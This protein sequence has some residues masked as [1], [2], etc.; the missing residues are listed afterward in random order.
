VPTSDPLE[1]VRQVIGMA[2]VLTQKDGNTDIKP[3]MEEISKLRQESRETEREMWKTQLADIKA[4]LEAKENAPT[5][6][7]LLPDGSNL[8]VIVEK[9]VA[10]AVENGLGESDNSWW[11]DPLKQLLPA[12][13]PVLG[14][15]LQ[16]FMQPAPAPPAFPMPPAHFQA[17]APM[18][19]Q[20]AQLPAPQQQPPPAVQ[21]QPGVFT[22]G[23]P[24]LDSLLMQI[25]VPLA[26]AL[27]GDGAPDS[28]AE[29]AEYFITEFGYD[30]F[31]QLAASGVEPIVQMLYAYPPL[32]STLKPLPRE[33]VVKFITEFTAFKPSAAGAT[34]GAA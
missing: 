15:M 11:V 4:R 3:L 30:T 18:P 16:R 1:M 29:F 27:R 8:N 24:Q 19:P 6:N 17:G 22:T 2:Q 10:K 20:P 9:A 33:S 12:A 13:M 25:V 31:T 7:V 14:A 34:G 5:S 26:D 32:V 28:G 21:P 23:I